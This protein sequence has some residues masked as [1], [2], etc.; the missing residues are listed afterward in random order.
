MGLV[1]K[2]KEDEV[3]RIK[4]KMVAVQKAKNRRPNMPGD[5]TLEIERAL[6][7][8]LAGMTHKQIAKTLNVSPEMVGRWIQDAVYGRIKEPADVIRQI[9]IERLDLMLLALATKVRAGDV[10]AIDRALKIMERR[11]RLLG[12][13]A[14]EKKDIGGSVEF[15]WR[16]DERRKPDDSDSSAETIP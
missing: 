1:R 4:G 6:N 5:R 10:Q 9:E 16:I 2:R 14:A 11:A 8:K 3:K 15:Q 12:L 7:L 13:D